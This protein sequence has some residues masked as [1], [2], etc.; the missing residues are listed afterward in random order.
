MAGVA[1]AG[2]C[3]DSIRT[4]TKVSVTTIRKVFLIAS[5][6]GIAVFILVP[7]YL[8]CE[9]KYG[10]IACLCLCT[11]FEAIGVTGGFV[12]N[13]IDIAPRYSSIIF[14]ISNTLATIPG[15]VAPIAVGEI[16]KTGTNEEWRLVFFI[17]AGISL[18]A[19]VLYGIF[20]DSELAPWAQGKEDP[21]EM[22]V[23]VSN[24]HVQQGLATVNES[25]EL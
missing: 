6:T 2:V 9:Y 1:V 13:I 4:R 15:I 14:G 24:K 16:T 20:A 18:F 3:A 25:C 17:T 21:I 8:T 23:Q 7:G 5:C 19:A 10:V 12:P 22:E 11:I